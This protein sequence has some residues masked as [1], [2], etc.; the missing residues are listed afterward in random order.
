MDLF[1]PSKKQLI[2]WAGISAFALLVLGVIYQIYANNGKD[3]L[4]AALNERVFIIILIALNSYFLAYFIAPFFY[5]KK[6]V[7][8]AILIDVPNEQKIVY[9]KLV[10]DLIPEYLASKS[11]EYKM[12]IATNEEYEEK[13]FT[14]L[15]EEVTELIRDKNIE[16]LA[17]LLEVID[18]VIMYKNFS[19]TDIEKLKQE[20]FEKRG[21]F[22]K[23]I[24]LEETTI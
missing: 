20:K 11:I 5:Q 1:Y 18:G 19:R 21:G 15:Q 17:D 14:K 12:H 3:E 4:I 9:N 2:I 16:E 10:R 13:L 22:S 6:E 23:K 8:A 24:I 7:Q